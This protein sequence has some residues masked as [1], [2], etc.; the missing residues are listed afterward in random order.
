MLSW[1][2]KNFPDYK[3][4]TVFKDTEKPE[5]KKVIDIKSAA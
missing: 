2:D 4:S 1:F 5:T 3:E